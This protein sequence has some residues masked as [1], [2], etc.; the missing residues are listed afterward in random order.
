MTNSPEL[1][2]KGGFRDL[3]LDERIKLLSYAI[4]DRNDLIETEEHECESKKNVLR[5]LAA[6]TVARE[7]GFI[8]SSGVETSVAYNL[9]ERIMAEGIRL[10]LRAAGF[11][12]END[13]RQMSIQQSF[14]FDSLLE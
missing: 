8:E 10:G 4:N 5:E 7:A 2:P 6:L 12:V 13:L 14:D 1:E 11:A 3:P 9:A